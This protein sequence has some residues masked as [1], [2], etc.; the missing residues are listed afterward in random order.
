MD[1]LSNW[2][3]NRC[4]ETTQLRYEIATF[5]ANVRKRIW[6]Y[7]Y[8]CQKANTGEVELESQGKSIGVII[9]EI[10]CL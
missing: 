5:E 2:F 1:D 9:N 7:D 10:L 3:L 4:F 6:V 8:S